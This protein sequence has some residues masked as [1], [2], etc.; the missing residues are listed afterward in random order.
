MCCSQ[1]ILVLAVGL[2]VRAAAPMQWP[3]VADHTEV[4]RRHPPGDCRDT[5]PPLD[6]I[7]WK[8]NYP[9]LVNASFTSGKGYARGMKAIRELAKKHPGEFDLLVGSGD[10][11]FPNQV[12]RA[13]SF[14]AASLIEGIVAKALSPLCGTCL[15]QL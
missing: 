10:Q 12:S 2:L 5:L 9:K 11:T 6:R 14:L 15:T 8:E 4:V 1:S 13:A 3:L 7:I